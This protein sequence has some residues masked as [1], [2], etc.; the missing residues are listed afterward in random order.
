MS[1]P[2]SQAREARPIRVL[3]LV[4]EFLDPLV[5]FAGAGFQHGALGEDLGQR[6]VGRQVDEG[7]VVEV[8]FEF[9]ARGRACDLAGI[10]AFPPFGDGIAYAALCGLVAGHFEDV[11]R[12]AEGYTSSTARRPQARPVTMSWQRVWS[13]Y[14]SGTL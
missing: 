2:G 8:R 13:V 11:E 12:I 7:A 6:V 5:G 14:D 4:V 3:D 9:G 10:E 1:Q